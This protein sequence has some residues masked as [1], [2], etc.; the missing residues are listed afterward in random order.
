MRLIGSFSIDILINFELRN[1]KEHKLTGKILWKLIR[2]K[3]YI[4]DINVLYHRD[5]LLCSLY[6]MTS[7]IQLRK[8]GYVPCTFFIYIDT[9]IHRHCC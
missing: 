2:I 6:L 3:R 1:M 8:N 7:K 9:I 5:Y 4:N